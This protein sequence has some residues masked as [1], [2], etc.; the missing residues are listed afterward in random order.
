[1]PYPRED[2]H[3]HIMFSRSQDEMTIIT[4]DLTIKRKLSKLAEQFPGVY[5]FVSEEDGVCEFICNKDRL[6]FKLPPTAKKRAALKAQM[7]R[8]N[9]VRAARKAAKET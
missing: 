3:T 1:M 5:E 6:S 2:E 7:E 9:E 8:M 4:G